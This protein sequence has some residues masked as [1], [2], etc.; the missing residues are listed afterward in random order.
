MNAIDIVFGAVLK[1]SLVCGMTA[2]ML[3]GY[4]EAVE[5]AA[6]ILESA[7]VYQENNVRAVE[8]LS[9]TTGSESGRI[10]RAEWEPKATQ[11]AGL[12][13]GLRAIVGLIAEEESKLNT[14]AA[15]AEKP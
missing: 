1:T 6:P 5:Y 4:R 14:E 9:E 7:V 8:G 3:A 2:T 11:A 12:I 13:V 10:C 15:A